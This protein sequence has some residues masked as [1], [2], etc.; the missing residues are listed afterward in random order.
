MELV[1]EELGQVSPFPR[2]YRLE[3]FASRSLSLD[4]WICLFFRDIRDVPVVKDI[5]SVK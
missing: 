4:D 1:E 5:R 2:Q 3:S